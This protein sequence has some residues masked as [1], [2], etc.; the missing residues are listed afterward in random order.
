MSPAATGMPVGLWKLDMWVGPGSC[1]IGIGIGPPQVGSDRKRRS[2]QVVSVRSRRTPPPWRWP[3]PE[4]RRPLTGSRKSAEREIVEP[5]A[6]RPGD[7]E[8]RIGLAV[9]H[10]EPDRPHRRERLAGDVGDGVADGHG[11]GAVVVVHQH[12]EE[13]P[14]VARPRSRSRIPAAAR[15]PCAPRPRR[16]SARQSTRGRC[17]RGRASWRRRRGA[18]SRRAARRRRRRRRR[19]RPSSRRRSRR[20]EGGARSGSPS[21]RRTRGS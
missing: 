14:G 8:D 3:P 2:P 21:R 18:A 16:R 19:G 4:T 10:V 1:I 20:P 17:S 11:L 7:G 5:F 9:V 12:V 15:A 13:A 6:A